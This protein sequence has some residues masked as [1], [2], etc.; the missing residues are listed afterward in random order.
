MANGT[1][2]TSKPA[3][4]D[5]INTEVDILYYYRPDRSSDSQNFTEGFKKIDS[6]IL[7]NAKFDNKILPGMFNLNLPVSIFS[8]I[9]FYTIYIRPKEYEVSV[10]DVSTLAA[11]PDV[12]GIVFRCN[13][14]GIKSESGEMNGYRI[15]LLDDNNE[16]TGEYRIITSS[17]RCEPVAQNLNNSMQKGIRYRLSDNGDLLFCTVTPSISMSFNTNSIPNIGK[18]GSIVRI[19][20][21]KFNPVMIE[22]EITEHDIESVSTML[23]GDQIRNLNNGLITTF[24]DDGTIY[25]QSSYGN[26]RSNK[27]NV[28][29]DFRITNNEI[30]YPE[31]IDTLERIKSTL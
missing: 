15:D 12:R 13:S 18:P 25:H 19:T 23:E 10:E 9:G 7:E 31:E 27:D 3:Y 14:D 20:N 22:L 1:Y 16:C 5:S 30:Y 2:G 29:S 17:N 11:Y 24:N 26:I 28:N 6:N 21:T 4:I 8:E